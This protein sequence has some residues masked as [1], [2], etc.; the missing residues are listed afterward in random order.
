MAASPRYRFESYRQYLKTQGIELHI[1]PLFDDDYLRDRLTNERAP[2]LAV[3][4]GVARRLYALARATRWDLVWLHY[5]LFPYLPARLE[6]LLG[7]GRL[8]YVLDIDDAIFHVYDQHRSSLVRG[9]LGQK[10]SR[11]MRRAVGIT[12]GSP[13]LVDFARQHNQRVHFVPTVVDLDRYPTHPQVRE[14]GPVRVGWIG[15]PSTTR[16]LETL[17]EPLRSLSARRPMEL[18]TVGARPFSM[19]GVNVSSLAWSEANEVRDLAT[20]DLGVMPLVDEPFARGKCAFKLIQYMATHLPVVAT[21]IGMNRSVV[22]KSCGFLCETP[23]QWVRAMATLAEDPKL[24]RSMGA[25]GRA[26][27]KKHYSLQAVAPRVRDALLEA[28][29]P[30][31]QNEMARLG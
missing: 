15:S 31:P 29:H 20:F 25:S 4:R 17:A 23:N 1:S 8:R 28:A 2:P 14:A 26:Q 30:Q 6:E 11:V 3:A 27:V 9:A 22:D 10:I 24:R 12:A 13:Y 7:T 19:P 21:P 18:V 5:E 16:Y